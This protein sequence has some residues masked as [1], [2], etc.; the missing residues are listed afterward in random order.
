MIKLGIA[1]WMMETVRLNVKYAGSI[2]HRDESGKLIDMLIQYMYSAKDLKLKISKDESIGEEMEFYCDARMG[3]KPHYGYLG[4][5][6]RKSSFIVAQS[7][8]ITQIVPLSPVDAESYALCI[9]TQVIIY[10][11]MIFKMLGKIIIKPT[12][13]Y[14]DNQTT[15]DMCYDVTKPNVSRYFVHRLDFI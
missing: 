14:C 7:K 3:A 6:N 10:I 1:R 13:I 8:A 5:M 9:V 2:A 4:R 12:I 15:V 11:H